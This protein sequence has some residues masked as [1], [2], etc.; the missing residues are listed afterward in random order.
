MRS[1]P[2]L[3]TLF[4]AASLAGA[5]SFGLPAHAAIGDVVWE[6]VP[7]EGVVE[8]GATVD[9]V[10]DVDG[11]GK[12]DVLVSGNVDDQGTL[13]GVAFVL[14]GADGSTLRTFHGSYTGIEIAEFIEVHAA[15]DFDHDDI[16]DFL[17]GVSAPSSVAPRGYLAVVSGKPACDGTILTGDCSQTA[18]ACVLLHVCGAVDEGFGA[19]VALAGD[20]DGDGVQDILARGGQGGIAAVRLYSGADG[21]VLWSTPV[22]G[23][24]LGGAAVVGDLVVTVLITGTL[25]AL[26]RSDGQ[27]V[28]TRDLAGG[29]NG[30]LSVAGDRLIVPIGMSNPPALLALGLAR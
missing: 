28:G 26:R 24:P 14:S 23:D 25:V 5:A 6:R 16:P 9:G 30:W 15:G 12:E 3:R 2:R 7:P 11:D 10:G 27:I 17:L 13:R 8:L 20:I 29:V 22:D 18:D 19:R 21:S 4:L 1:S